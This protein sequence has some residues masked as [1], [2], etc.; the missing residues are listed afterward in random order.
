MVV[1]PAINDGFGRTLIE[2]ML[3]RVP[4]IASRSGGHVEIIKSGY[5][6][7]LVDLFDYNSYAKEAI[8]ILSDINFRKA[9]IHRA[10]IFA[11]SNFIRKNSLKINSLL[12]CYQNIITN[13]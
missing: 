11:K 1:V 9:I 8:N 2:S 13:F 10:Y 3:H 6:G 5:N 7:V 12:K 4:V